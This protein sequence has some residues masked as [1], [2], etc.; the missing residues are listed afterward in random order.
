MSNTLIRYLPEFADDFN[1]YSDHDKN[2]IRTA[3]EKLSANPLSVKD[4]GYGNVVSVNE[5]GSVMCVK[6]IFTGIRII[7]KL[8]KSADNNLLIFVSVSNDNIQSTL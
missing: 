5:T 8:M 3:V 7:Y 4:G 1:R 6:I 2:I